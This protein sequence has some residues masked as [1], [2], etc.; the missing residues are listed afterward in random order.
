MSRVPICPQVL[1]NSINMD[2]I[3]N[4]LSMFALVLI[5][6]SLGYFFN[7]SWIRPFL[8][9]PAESTSLMG[10]FLLLKP[11]SNIRFETI[12]YALQIGIIVV[13]FLLADVWFKLLVFLGAGC[14]SEEGVALTFVTFLM[15]SGWKFDVYLM[16][17][18]RRVKERLGCPLTSTPH[19][20][21]KIKL[22]WALRLVKF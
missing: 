11:P 6:L 8:W 2:T 4:I 20:L 15:I 13:F 22:K 10:T 3:L 16:D 12:P 1:P 19:M 5:P 7:T 21:A 14:Q 9:I 17:L 18:G